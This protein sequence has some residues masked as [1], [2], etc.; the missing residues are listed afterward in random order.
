MSLAVL[1]RQC[2]GRISLCGISGSAVVGVLLAALP[3]VA[4]Q[5]AAD[6]VATT[7]QVSAGGTITYIDPTMTEPITALSVHAL[8]GTYSISPTGSTATSHDFTVTAAHFSDDAGTSFDL[9]PGTN[10]FTCEDSNNMMCAPDFTLAA[11][12]FPIY[13]PAVTT[14][15]NT[16]TTVVRESTLEPD[17]PEWAGDVTDQTGHDWLQQVGQGNYTGVGMY[18]YTGGSDAQGNPAIEMVAIVK[19]FDSKMDAAPGPPA[20]YTVDAGATITYSDPTNDAPATTL[21]QR[22]LTGSYTISLAPSSGLPGAHVYTVTAA[23]FQDDN[24]TSFDQF[25]PGQLECFDQYGTCAPQ[26]SLSAQNFPVYDSS[27]TDNVRTTSTVIQETGLTGPDDPRWVGDELD[28]TGFTWDQSN[29]YVDGYGM[30]RDN[31]GGLELVAI[32]KF[33]ATK[34]VPDT[35]APVVT[36][37]SPQDAGSYTVGASVAA[38]YSC[39]DASVVQSCAGPAA[40]GAAI[41]TSTPGAYTFTVTG[42][43]AAGNT[44]SSTVSYTVAAPPHGL[45]VGDVTVSEGNSGTTAMVFPVSLTPPSATAVKVSYATSDGSAA[46]GSDYVA[47]TGTLTIPAGAGGGTISVNIHG[48][49]AVEPDESLSLTLASPSPA[50]IPILRSTAIGTI[51]NDDTA[52]GITVHD[53]SLAEGNSGTSSMAFPITLN[54][55]AASAIKLTYSTSDGSATAPSDYKSKTGSVTIAA[56][57]TTASVAVSIVGDSTVEPD[58]HFTVQLTGVTS[59]PGAIIGATAIGTIQNDDL[60]ASATV[61]PAQVTEG[62]SGHVT[63]QFPVTLDQPATGT[64]KIGYSTSDG[65]ATAPSDYAAKTGTVSIPAGARSASIPIVVNGDVAVEPNESMT[66]TLTS[67]VSGPGAIAGPSA[68]GTIIN[69]DVAAQ[70]SVED[71]TVS[72]GNSG[73]TVMTFTVSLDKPAAAAIKIAYATA[74]GTAVAPSDYT[75]K[76]GTITIPVGKS[77]ATLAVK[78][79][80]DK[81]TEPDESL[82][83]NLT[84]VVSGPAVISRASATGTILSDD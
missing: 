10:S 55:P 43:D 73:T 49:V 70:A 34:F 69:D 54:T 39:A 61:G 64:I 72:E 23:H 13:D 19:F 35:T 84:L 17:G 22:S 3:A 44:S 4:T 32:I 36:I 6:P 59:G 37:T 75:A 18:R 62:D 46:A 16:T 52:S 30:Y 53:A 47:K 21:Y 33:T 2:F 5:A 45:S 20:T 31:D 7:Y 26:I 38:Q 24:G 27:V 9:G 83:L 28:P 63:M 76:T 29:Q 79:N 51:S 58:E 65:T 68:A 74:D 48:D 78:V 11:T 82:D 14:A 40:T 12:G 67:V 41:D 56:G 71:V 42:V 25:G 60:L 15:P 50:S 8:S 81:T 1:R 77:S 66:L 80:G 57:A